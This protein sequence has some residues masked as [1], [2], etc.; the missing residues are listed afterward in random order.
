MH[1]ASTIAVLP[2]PGS[3]S[4]RT[5]AP[6]LTLCLPIFVRAAAKALS[7][8]LYSLFVILISLQ[9]LSSMTITASSAFTTSATAAVSS[10]AFLAASSEISRS[11]S[12]KSSTW[13][14]IS[15]AISLTEPVVSILSSASINL[16][17]TNFLIF[18]L[19]FLLS[20]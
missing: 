2:E 15:S 4:T 1:Q 10:A 19:L 16:D 3:P 18:I 11:P 8:V 17:S 7:N 14:L 5:L 9:S 12:V 20:L 6:A 13:S